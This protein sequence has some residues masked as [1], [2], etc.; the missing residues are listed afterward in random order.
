MQDNADV[1][2][3]C[4]GIWEGDDYVPDV[5]EDWVNESNGLLAVAEWNG[6]AIA[7]SKI[8]WISRGQWWLEGFRVD[9]AYQGL[10]IGACIHDYVTNW[11]LTHGD[12]TL[13]L[14][15]DAGNVAVHRLCVKTGYVK[16][17]EVCGYKAD[18]LAEPTQNFSPVV[19]KLEAAQF[20]MESESI[21][22]TDG[23]LDF[24]WRI[25]L[26]DEAALDIS[27]QADRDHTF[28]WWKDRQGLFSAW[29]N[30]DEAENIR[31]LHVGVVA[32]ALSDMPAL[33]MDA[34][35]L[36]A[37]Q[38]LDFVFQIAFDIPAIIA[39]LYAAGF[40]KKWKRSNAFVFEKKHPDRG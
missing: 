34:R 38:K 37:Q 4:K 16:T 10:K 9:P 26:L 13:R 2:E 33:L 40:E 25:G 17:Y 19:N 21:Q 8:S 23:L 22:T 36:A 29:V 35:R 3:F 31:T 5:W 7:C 27:S 24:G 30:E 18:V 1:T 6:H 28:Y 39:Q 32:C 20:G 11:W 12:G 14:M 15:T